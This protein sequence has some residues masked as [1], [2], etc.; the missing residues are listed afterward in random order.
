V[1]R[2]WESKSVEEQVNNRQAESETPSKKKASRLEIERNSK[3]ESIL[4]ARSRASR[5][6]QSTQDDRYRALL[7]RTLAHLDSELAKLG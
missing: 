6:L 4:L 7:E 5:D 1:A 3:R 2:G